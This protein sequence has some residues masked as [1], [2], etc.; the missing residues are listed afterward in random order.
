MLYMVNIIMMEGDIRRS[1]LMI[2]CRLTNLCLSVQTIS[3]TGKFIHLTPARTTNTTLPSGRGGW[4][5]GFDTTIATL[6]SYRVS[7]C[8]SF[9]IHVLTFANKQKTTCNEQCLMHTITV[10]VDTPKMYCL[11]MNA[12]CS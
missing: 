12:R 11:A 10:S 8:C 5:T 1:F 9:A 4:Y 3:E 6:P 7:Q 2:S